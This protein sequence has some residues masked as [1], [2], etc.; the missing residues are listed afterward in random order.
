MCDFFF[1][2]NKVG[3]ET[4][5]AAQ[6]APKLK[7]RK[8]AIIPCCNIGCERDHAVTHVFK[9]TDDML[10]PPP[11][12]DD[13][14]KACANCGALTTGVSQCLTCQKFICLV[15]Y[16]TDTYNDQLCAQF[17]CQSCTELMSHEEVEEEDMSLMMPLDKIYFV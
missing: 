16:T 15:C 10:E 4:K 8:A 9:Q 17:F 13:P 5:K 3:K 11:L 2:L 12:P 1:V 14:Q 6:K 7:K